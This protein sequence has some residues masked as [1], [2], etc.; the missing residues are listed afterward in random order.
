VLDRGT[1]V[2]IVTSSD[3]ERAR[4]LASLGGPA[5]LAGAHAADPSPST[6]TT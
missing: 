4:G 5:A 2:G 3:L 6:W 1:L